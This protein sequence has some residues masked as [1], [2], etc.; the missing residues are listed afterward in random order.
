MTSGA[1]PSPFRRAIRATRG[2]CANSPFLAAKTPEDTWVEWTL[3]PDF[4]GW[5]AVQG[6]Y[7]KRETL[8]VEIDGQTLIRDFVR[9]ADFLGE[10]IISKHT[11]QL[12]AD[13]VALMEQVDDHGIAVGYAPEIAN[14]PTMKLILALAETTALALHAEMVAQK[15]SALA[16]ETADRQRELEQNQAYMLDVVEH[17]KRKMFVIPW[18]ENQKVT[19]PKN[20]RSQVGIEFKTLARNVL[21]YDAD[22]YPKE[23]FGSL[24]CHCYPLAV[25]EK[26]GPIWIRINKEVSERKAWFRF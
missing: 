5:Q 15:A 17:G 21:G 14:H 10:A 7:R 2:L 8:Q 22:Q 11:P 19:V 13:A 26:V 4:V 9:R 1:T 25:L 6:L 18:L 24:Y 20:M 16:Q 3:I 12:R 23:P